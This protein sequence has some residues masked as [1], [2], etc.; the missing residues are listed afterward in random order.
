MFNNSISLQSSHWQVSI[1]LIVFF[2]FVKI[3][4]LLTFY[5]CILHIVYNTILTTGRH[6]IGFSFLIPPNVP[7]SFEMQYGSIKYKL[8]VK[9]SGQ[10]IENADL[11][12][13]ILSSPI[14]SINELLVCDLILFSNKLENFVFNNLII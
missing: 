10:E 12:L 14:V 13:N 9:V 8:K 3:L 7:S 2:F 4:P 1:D 11:N 6:D 5:I